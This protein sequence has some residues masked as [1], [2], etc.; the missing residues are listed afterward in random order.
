MKNISNQ[1]FI[2]DL[3]SFLYGEEEAEILDIIEKTRFVCQ[4]AAALTKLI[5]ITDQIDDSA[6][7]ENGKHCGRKFGAKTVKRGRLDI[8]SH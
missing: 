2:T 3:N 6:D 7:V 5:L 1:H 4:S 8:E